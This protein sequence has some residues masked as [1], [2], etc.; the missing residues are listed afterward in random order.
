MEKEVTKLTYTNEQPTEP[1]KWYWF[2]GNDETPEAIRWTRD[3]P[4]PV[5]C[6]S[7]GFNE[8]LMIFLGKLFY[9]VDTIGGQWAGPI[10]E[11]E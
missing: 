3:R 10:E 9:Y 7:D 2:R 1:N 6:N 11:P 4:C 5:R 8:V